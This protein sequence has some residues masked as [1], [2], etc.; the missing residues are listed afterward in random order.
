MTTFGPKKDE[1]VALDNLNWGE[2]ARAQYVRDQ[3]DIA[4][5][6]HREYFRKRANT[7]VSTRKAMS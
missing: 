2:G 7:K 5:T 6:S 1:I 3:M 4:G